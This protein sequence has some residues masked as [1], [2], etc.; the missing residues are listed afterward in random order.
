MAATPSKIDRNRRMRDALELR[1]AG[2]PYAV[3]AE[4]LG[5]KSP[6]AAYKAVKKALDTQINEP[7]EE[8]R[9]IEIER[10]NHLLMLTWARIQ[11]GDLRSVDAAMRIMERISS[12]RGI[13]AARVAQRTERGVLVIDGD[14][15]DDYIASLS[16]VNND[17]SVA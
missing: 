14:D 12:L 17:S 11:Q 2:V 16:Q 9:Q 13:D 10:L 15:E 5:W 3:I 8:L 7:V 6:Q 1:K 4:R